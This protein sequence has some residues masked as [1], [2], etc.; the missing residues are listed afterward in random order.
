M[1]GEV[2]RMQTDWEDLTSTVEWMASSGVAGNSE[3]RIRDNSSNLHSWD[4]ER[5]CVNDTR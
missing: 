1:R 5:C 3:R 2:V 4:T